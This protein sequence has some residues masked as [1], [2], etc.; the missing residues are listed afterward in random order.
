MRRNLLVHIR[1]PHDYIGKIVKI[2]LPY[3]DVK[4]AKV[5]FKSRPGLII[6]CE[7]NQFPCDF[8][9]LPISKISDES[10]R[11][12][13][14]DFEVNDETCNLLNLNNVPSFVRCHKVSTV[15][16]K[17]V[18]RNYISDLNETNNRLFNEIKSIFDAFATGLF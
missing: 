4:S 12:S 18:H 8:T 6:G 16:S 5:A 15:Y 14:Y 11:H 3:Y 17:N 10:K 2:R 13:I 9:Y 7:K 1:S